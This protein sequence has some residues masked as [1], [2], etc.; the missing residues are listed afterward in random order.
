VQLLTRH[1][2]YAVRALCYIARQGDCV[3]S[4]TELSDKLKIPKPFLRSILQIL[5]RKRILNSFK[6]KHGGFSLAKEPAEILLTDITS[7]FQG[8]L[9]LNRCITRSGPCPDFRN[10]PLKKKLQQIEQY[11]ASELKAVTL[12]SLLDD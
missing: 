5:R 10:C 2:H 7:A 1:T 11:I 8:P 12:Q 4:V 6:G 3:V 9:K